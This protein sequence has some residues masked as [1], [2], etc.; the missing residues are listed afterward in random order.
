[1][2]NSSAIEHTIE[3]PILTFLYNYFKSDMSLVWQQVRLKDIS[4]KSNRYNKLNGKTSQ[5]SQTIQTSKT[6]K[7]GQIVGHILCPDVNIF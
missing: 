1:L 4:S 3:E 7:T 5:R 2:L 6:C